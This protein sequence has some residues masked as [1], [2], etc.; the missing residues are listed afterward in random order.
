MESPN[1]HFRSVVL[2]IG[3]DRRRT[4][5]GPCFRRLARAAKLDRLLD[6]LDRDVPFPAAAAG[7]RG[8]QGSAATVSLP[9]GW[10]TDPDDC[11]VP[12][13]AEVMNSGG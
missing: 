10:L 13:G 9:D 2:M 6:G 11:T 3:E 5:R 7:P 8:R 12:A 1:E 4:R